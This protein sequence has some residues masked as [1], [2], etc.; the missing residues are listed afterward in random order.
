MKSPPAEQCHSVLYWQEH[1]VA[2]VQLDEA[3]K[4]PPRHLRSGWQITPIWRECQPQRGL[5]E[6][7]VN[8]PRSWPSVWLVCCFSRNKTYWVKW[9]R[10]ISLPHT[11][12]TCR[13]TS[14]TSPNRQHTHN[15]ITLEVWTT[16]VN[17][18]LCCGVYLSSVPVWGNFFT[19]TH[20]NHY[21]RSQGH[22]K[23]ILQGVLLKPKPSLWWWP[24]S[25]FSLN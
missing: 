23:N 15:E 5:W 10:C 3:P 14:S 13:H 2:R 8:A 18:G 25:L 6:M 19:A 7:P 9:R 22:G 16:D 20:H 21:H 24:N 12:T 17:S 4:V 1:I 11:D